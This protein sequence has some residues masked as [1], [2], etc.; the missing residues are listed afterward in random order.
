MGRKRSCKICTS[1]SAITSQVNAQIEAGVRQKV[2]H[3]QFPQFSVSKLSR[4]SRGCLA[5]K[6]EAERANESG[7]AKHAKWLERAESTFL[8]AQANG[9][10]KSAAQAISVAVRAL[11]AM[12]KKQAE[13]AEADKAGADDRHSIQAIDEQLRNFMAQRDVANDGVSAKAQSLLIEEPAFCSLVFA[14][15]KNR[16]LL[17]ALLN[18]SATYFPERKLENVQPNN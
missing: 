17:P 5:P 4:H 1:D 12:H 14:V 11:T 7:S 18:T 2:I 15:W 3:E 10:T 9:D 13:E 16:A 8:V 6:P